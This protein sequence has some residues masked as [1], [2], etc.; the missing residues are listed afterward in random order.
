MQK[1]EVG[2]QGAADDNNGDD[3]LV[4]ESDSADSVQS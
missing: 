3:V 4:W 2:D 1:S